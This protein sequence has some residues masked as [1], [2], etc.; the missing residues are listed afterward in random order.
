MASHVLRGPLRS[1]VN[2]FQR[3]GVLVCEWS[4]MRIAVLPNHSV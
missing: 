4:G 2:A 3:N 1:A